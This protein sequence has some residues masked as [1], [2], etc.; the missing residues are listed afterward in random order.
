MQTL[1]R[2]C[3]IFTV[4]EKH[5][6]KVKGYAL[7]AAMLP[8]PA[9]GAQ[10]DFLHFKLL[11]TYSATICTEKY[12]QTVSLRHCFT[13]VLLITF[14]FPQARLLRSR[15]STPQTG[16]FQK[17]HSPRSSILWESST[18]ISKSSNSSSSNNSSSS[19]SSKTLARGKASRSQ[20]ACP[21]LQL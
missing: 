2:A 3:S 4:Q 9:R 13:A 18:C 12:T 11:S 1:E 8:R 19:S 15:K 7:D 10:V 16:G 20:H 21:H 6:W 17:Q 14:C 5:G